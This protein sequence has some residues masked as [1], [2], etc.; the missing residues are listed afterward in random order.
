MW[1][2]PQIEHSISAACHSGLTTQTRSFREHIGCC[3]YTGRV[4]RFVQEQFHTERSSNRPTAHILSKPWQ[5]RATPRQYITLQQLFCEIAREFL[6]NM[7]NFE[8]VQLLSFS[9][10]CTS[11]RVKLTTAFFLAHFV[12]HSLIT[13]TDT[14]VG[15]YVINFAQNASAC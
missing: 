9:L 7:R 1:S 5:K 3:R 4:S 15:I 8:A 10:M 11:R 14:V 13:L 6:F 2:R 12:R